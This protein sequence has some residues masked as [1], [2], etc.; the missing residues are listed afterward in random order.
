M[1]WKVLLVLN[2]IYFNVGNKIEKQNLPVACLTFHIKLCTSCNIVKIN[3]IY[4]SRGHLS[5]QKLIWSS[6][7]S[8]IWEKR[9][10]KWARTP[11]RHHPNEKWFYI[12]STYAAGKSSLAQMH[13]LYL[14]MQEIWAN[15]QRSMKF[16]P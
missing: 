11:R 5:N 9:E 6:I 15:Q 4:I 14:F 12:W 3:V 1:N 16:N 8:L 7:I 2:F 10:Q 13:S